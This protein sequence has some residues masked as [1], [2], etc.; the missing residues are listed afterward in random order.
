MNK[1]LTIVSIILF[2]FFIFCN[3]LS[4]KEKTILEFEKL[5]ISLDENIEIV[6][7]NISG[8]TD[9][10]LDIEIKADSLN[11]GKVEEFIKNEKG[12]FVGDTTTDVELF[13]NYPYLKNNQLFWEKYE[14]TDVAFEYLKIEANIETRIIKF[15]FMEE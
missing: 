10:I 3:T 1:F 8:L 11:F 6:E 14:P 9:Y 4:D 13:N 5:N 15:H 12:F 7:F 2:V